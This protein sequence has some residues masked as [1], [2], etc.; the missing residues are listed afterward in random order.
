MSGRGFSLSYVIRDG[1]HAYHPAG[2]VYERIAGKGQGFRI[3]DL[4]GCR[5]RVK[6]RT[7]PKEG[8][9]FV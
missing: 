6:V 3:L 8:W 5:V 4:A 9:L 1:G 2:W 7:M